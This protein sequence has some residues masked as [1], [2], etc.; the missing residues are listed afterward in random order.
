MYNSY[1]NM[2]NNYEIPLNLAQFAKEFRKS[3]NIYK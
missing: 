2:Y 3:E 1:S